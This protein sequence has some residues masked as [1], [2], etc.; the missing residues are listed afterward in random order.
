[1][2]IAMGPYVL[3][4]VLVTG[5]RGD[6][7]RLADPGRRPAAAAGNLRLVRLPRGHC[8]ASRRG[9]DAGL[10]RALGAGTNEGH[11]LASTEAGEAREA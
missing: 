6:R 2:R 1:M 3:G 10:P 4:A 8:R 5:G 11:P 9:R 7:E